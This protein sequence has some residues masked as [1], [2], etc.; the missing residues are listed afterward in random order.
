MTEW[1]RANPRVIFIPVSLD[2]SAGDAV[3][4]LDSRGIDLPVLLTDESQARGVGA[5]SLPTTMVIA[6]DGSVIQHHRGSR[7]WT[8][9][10][11]TGQLLKGLGLATP[12]GRTGIE[13]YDGREEAL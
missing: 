5:S 1:V 2:R 13:R 7:D 12:S 11:F 6:G 3:R 8:S 4:F 9:G 10:A